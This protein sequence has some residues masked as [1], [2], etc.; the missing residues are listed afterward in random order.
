MPPDIKLFYYR[1]NILNK[2]TVGL[3]FAKQ[4]HEDWAMPFL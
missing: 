1:G 2:M 3:F 4:E